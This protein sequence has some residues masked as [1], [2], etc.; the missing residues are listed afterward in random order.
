MTMLLLKTS[1]VYKLFQ[2]ID[3]YS[4]NVTMIMSG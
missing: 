2:D 3:M 4:I 1:I